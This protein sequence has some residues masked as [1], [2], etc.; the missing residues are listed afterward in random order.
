MA[1]GH[2]NMWRQHSRVLGLCMGVVAPMIVHVHVLCS[3]LTKT[4][5]WTLLG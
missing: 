5:P 3:V 1:R 4:W 2:A